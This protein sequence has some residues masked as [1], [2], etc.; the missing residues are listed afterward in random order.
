MADSGNDREAAAPAP[1]A[2][3]AA[4]IRGDSTTSTRSS[5][6]ARYPDIVA[7]LRER[8][9]TP[10]GQHVP[11]LVDETLAALAPAPGRARRRCDP[12]LGRPRAALARAHRAPAA[13]CWRSTPIRSSCRGRRR[14]CARSA[15]TR[16]RWWS[17]GRTSPAL[18]RR[19]TRPA[20]TTASISCS[21][22]LACRR[23]RSTTRRA[24][25]RS[26]TKGR[27]TCG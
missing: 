1:A 20:G 19:S 27:S 10:A 9:L 5:R 8:G 17:G 21:P 13:A 7:H 18:A 26:S 15:S 6:P 23:C 24:A 11:V 2:L 25:S 3:P 4:R 16:T 12:R 14:A 22:T